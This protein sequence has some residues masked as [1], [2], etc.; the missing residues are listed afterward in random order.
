[1]CPDINRSIIENLLSKSTHLP[2]DVSAEGLL[3]RPSDGPVLTINL[4]LK[5]R[6][7]FRLLI[8][9]NQLG[10]SS[11]LG[12]ASVYFVIIPTLPAATVI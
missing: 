10:A 5:T 6:N 11:K 3:G 1:M 2:L 7:Y 4:F 9:S 12:S 8:Q